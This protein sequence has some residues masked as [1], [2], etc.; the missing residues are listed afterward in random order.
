[1]LLGAKYLIYTEHKNVTLSNLNCCCV[2][3]CNSFMEEYGP[4]IYYLS[5]KMTQ[6]IHPHNSDVLPIPE[7]E[8]HPIFLFDFTA[9]Q[10]FLKL[11][12]ANAAENKPVDLEWIHNYTWVLNLLQR[13]LITLTNTSTKIYG[14][15]SLCVFPSLMRIV[16]CTA[17]LQSQKK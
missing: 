14:V 6:L 4:N 16:S 15:T 9:T 12:L 10:C 1:M 17:K 11:P 3:H 5:K 8:N 2:L 7:W 13:Q